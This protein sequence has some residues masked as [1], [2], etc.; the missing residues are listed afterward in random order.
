[1]EAA[2]TSDE[3]VAGTQKQVIGVAENDLR[4]ALDQV[5]VKRGLDRPLRANGHERRRLHE[6]MRRFER[7]QSRGAVSA[8]QCEAKRRALSVVEGASQHDYY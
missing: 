7:A 3:L 4:A 5:A 2:A 8:A 6:T 1:V